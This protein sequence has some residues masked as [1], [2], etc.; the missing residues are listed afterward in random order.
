MIPP[1]LT[2]SELDAVCGVLADHHNI[3]RAIIFGSRAK[4]T[5]R[6]NSDIDMQSIAGDL[7]ELSLA[8]RYDVVALRHATNEALLEHVERV[9]V[10]I[11]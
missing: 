11:R 2:S 10:E 9:G 4:G 5:N 1:V 3:T 7:D 6:P 8:Y